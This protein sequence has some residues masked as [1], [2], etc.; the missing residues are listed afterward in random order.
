[1]QKNNLGSHVLFCC[2]QRQDQR[3]HAKSET[4]EV[5]SEH[6]ET[7]CYTE[8][9][10]ALAQVAQRGCEASILADIQKPSGHGP[11]KTRALCEQRGLDHMTS[12]GPFQPHACYDSAADVSDSNLAEIRGACLLTHLSV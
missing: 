12:R 2:A 3:Q 11:R 8:C 9:D 7:L 1:L 6:K 5:P 4:Q 10:R